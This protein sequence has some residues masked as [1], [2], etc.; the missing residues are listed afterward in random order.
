MPS[1][2]WNYIVY[3][4]GIIHSKK[5]IEYHSHKKYNSDENYAARKAFPGVGAETALLTLDAGQYNGQ[6]AGAG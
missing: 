4:R 3:C 5:H 6:R 1:S 2:L